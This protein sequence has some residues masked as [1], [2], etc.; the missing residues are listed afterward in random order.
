MFTTLFIQ[1]MLIQRMIVLAVLLVLVAACGRGREEATAAPAEPAA[2]SAPA[3]PTTAP[4]AAPTTAA[5]T[6]LPEAPPAIAI[7]DDPTVAVTEAMSAQMNG[8]PYRVTTSVDAEGTVTEMVAEIIPPDHIHVT[9]GG[10]NL[11]M[12]LIDGTLWSKSGGAE[13]AQVGSPDM[14]QGILDTVQGQIDAG[15]LVNVQ[16][17]GEEPVMGEATNVY[18][19]TS[20]VGEGDDAATTDVKM[21]VSKLTGLPVRMEATSVA[22]GV[23]SQIIQAFEYDDTITIEPPAQ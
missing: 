7:S 23:T 16:H 4:T 21:W 3:A 22:M 20:T 15:T 5:A 13:W 9:I 12:I 19:Y 10:G 1:R 14:M 8:G 6:A 17:V 11:E 2:A 18:S